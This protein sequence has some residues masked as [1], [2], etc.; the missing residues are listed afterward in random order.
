[1]V[2]SSYPIYLFLYLKSTEHLR[3]RVKCVTRVYSNSYANNHCAQPV[4]RRFALPRLVLVI[5]KLYF[6][7]RKLR[8][9]L[10]E[11]TRRTLGIRRMKVYTRAEA[12]NLKV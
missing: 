2:T 9:G 12:V 10:R 3:L 6:V 1:M 11:R 7:G 4:V 5:I 8:N